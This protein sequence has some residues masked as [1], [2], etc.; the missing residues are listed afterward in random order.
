MAE[1]VV[2]PG[3]SAKEASLQEKGQGRRTV[4][5]VVDKFDYHGSNINGP[6]RYFSRLARNIDESRFRPVL[7]SLRDSSGSEAFFRKRGLDVRYLG[8]GR[9]NP[10][11]ITRIARLAGDVGAD[12]LHLNGYAA[13]SLGR[14]AA[15]LAGIPCIVHENW[16]DPGFSTVHS[17]FWGILSRFPATTYANSYYTK[18][19]VVRQKG[20]NPSQVQ[21]IYNGIPVDDFRRVDPGEGR[22]VRREL[23]VPPNELV[24]GLVGMFHSN[25]GHHDFL[26]SASK[27]VERRPDVRFVLVGD[28]ELREELK[29]LTVDLKLEDRVVFAGQREDMPAVL[30]MIDVWVS[31]SYTESFGTGV[32]E[33]M[34]AGRAIVCTRS[35]GPEETLDDGVTALMV[36][37]GDPRAMAEAIERFL[38]DEKLRLQFGR[39]AAREAEKY[40]VSEMVAR[41]EELYEDL[42][43]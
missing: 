14:V 17:L 15:Q 23:S 18:E 31:A 6:T 22:R 28:G 41:I 24:V 8:L 9:F 39:R 16:V 21:V 1:L 27:I 33:A 5:M 2:E 40:E 42:C 38:D 10:L 25:K 11:T 32:V 19:F 12:V 29:N 7:C 35:G 26:A 20:A 3:H 4:L 13:T 43:S 37:P 34:A 36:P 30:S